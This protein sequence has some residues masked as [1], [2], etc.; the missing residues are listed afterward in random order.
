MK[1]DGVL[2]VDFRHN[3]CT[4]GCAGL[5]TES[6]GGQP[7]SRTGPLS[8]QILANLLWPKTR[9]LIVGRSVVARSTSRKRRGLSGLKPRTLQ[10]CVAESGKKIALLH[11]SALRISSL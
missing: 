3:A 8:R 1:C 10:T 2:V 5:C 9:S 7:K 4:Y 11:Q 6:K